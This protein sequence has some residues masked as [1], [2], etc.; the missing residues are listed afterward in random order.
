MVE[1]GW[2]PDVVGV[3]V[4]EKK[5]LCKRPAALA[6]MHEKGGPSQRQRS[7]SVGQVPDLGV[8]DAGVV[9]TLVD[10]IA[11]GDDVASEGTAT[12][13]S[14]DAASEVDL[15]VVEV[16]CPALSRGCTRKEKS[17]D[18]RTVLEG[19]YYRSM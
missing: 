7:G 3:G 8:S 4:L 15:G 19:V 2:K 17:H 13:V 5:R 18:V 10:S 12:N 16:G 14:G 9:G 11:V 1:I 6:V